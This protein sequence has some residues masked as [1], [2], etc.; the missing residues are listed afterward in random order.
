MS[1]LL[2]AIVIG[3]IVL[4]VAML[5]TEGL[6]SSAIMLLN[7]ILAGLL[8]MNFWEPASSWLLSYSNGG[9]FFWDF[10][11]LVGLFLVF[12]VIFR[13]ITDKLS[14]KRVVFH[15]AVDIGGGVFLAAFTGWVLS[16]FLLAAVQT[17]PIPREFAWGGFVPEENNIFGLGPDRLWLGFTQRMSMGPLAPIGASD[18]PNGPHVFDPKGEYILKYATHRARYATMDSVDAGISGV[19]L[20]PAAPTQ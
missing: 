10:F 14:K 7:V 9:E 5:G 6:W 3:C 12:L 13:S 16:C 18:D 2:S 15:K 19:V 20:P 1:L 17:A 8:A 11:A 4:I